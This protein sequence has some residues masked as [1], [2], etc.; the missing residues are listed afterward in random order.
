M[1]T[2]KD[3]DEDIFLQWLSAKRRSAR[4]PEPICSDWTDDCRIIEEPFLCWL[5]GP[6]LFSDLNV[7]FTTPVSD[8]FCPYSTNTIKAYTP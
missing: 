2:E 6:R 5:G 3:K 7:V 4:I 1:S 8:G